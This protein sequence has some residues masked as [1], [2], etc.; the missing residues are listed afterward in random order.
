MV[1]FGK[2]TYDLTMSYF[3]YK[4]ST[5][6]DQIATVWKFYNKEFH[7]QL[8]QECKEMFGQDVQVAGQLVIQSTDTFSNWKVAYMDPMKRN[9]FLGAFYLI[10]YT[11]THYIHLPVSGNKGKG[12]IV[13]EI[14]V[15]QA[16]WRKKGICLVKDK[17]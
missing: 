1:F 4:L 2:L 15:Y 6:A 9:K 17:E 16:V 8:G 10:Y 14:E 13:L 5:A 12:S 7:R 11:P 3:N